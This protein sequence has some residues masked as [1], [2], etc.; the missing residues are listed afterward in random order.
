MK[1]VRALCWGLHRHET[2][3]SVSTVCSSSGSPGWAGGTNSP[4][5]T[6]RVCDSV[7]PGSCDKARW[8]RCCCQG[9]RWCREELPC[10]WGWAMAWSQELHLGREQDLHA[11]CRKMYHLLPLNS[12]LQCFEPEPVQSTW[13]WFLFF[14]F[15]LLLS[16]T[17]LDK[18][19]FGKLKPF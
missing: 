1:C 3:H 5:V 19:L 7:G 13:C 6:P 15:C 17:I 11:A 16:E 9:W 8:H 14:F 10:R 12:L 4:R 2:L 18:S